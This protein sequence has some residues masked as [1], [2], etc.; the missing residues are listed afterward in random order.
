MAPPGSLSWPCS[1]YISTFS[2]HPP[3]STHLINSALPSTNSAWPSQLL[4]RC[5]FLMCLIILQMRL[6]LIKANKWPISMKDVLLEQPSWWTIYSLTA[7]TSQN[8]FGFCL[9]TSILRY[10][11][12]REH[13]CSFVMS[14]FF[15]QRRFDFIL[16]TEIVKYLKIKLGQ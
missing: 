2:L 15:F 8:T 4:Y 1:G 11:F 5:L 9:Y 7:I 16:S 14:H 12:W 3:S 6:S 13:F 10:S